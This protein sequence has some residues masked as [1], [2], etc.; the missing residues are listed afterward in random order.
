MKKKF[1]KQQDKRWFAMKDKRKKD[2]TKYGKEYVNPPVYPVK[3]YDRDGNLI[4]EIEV[5]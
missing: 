1:S 2:I 3:R 5:C 4:E